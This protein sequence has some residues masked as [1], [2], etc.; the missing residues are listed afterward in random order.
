MSSG[1][2]IGECA[3]LACVLEATGRKPGNVTRFHDFD[4]LTYLDFVLSACAIAPVL[5]R[6]PELGVGPAILEAIRATRRFVTTN[7]NLGIVLLL[8]PLAATPREQPIRDGID[9]VLSG[10]TVADSRAAFEAIRLA[11][12]GGLGEAP[13]QDVRGKPT[14]PL[15]QAMALAA[16]RDLIAR[17]YAN[18]FREVFEIGVPELQSGPVEQAL[19][20]CQLRLMSVCIDSHIARKCGL[21]AAEEVRRRAATVE[22]S[23]AKAIA[24]FDSWL[25]HDGHRLNPGSTADLVAACLFIA[26]R[27][28]RIAVPIEFYEKPARR[29]P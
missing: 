15:Q 2:S 24:R 7:T 19:I 26:L 9:P 13:E 8:A 3:Q 17:Q 10:L 4:D 25:R 6:T 23:D 22:V 18:G 14:L 27:E 21:A 20:R 5:E 28:G 16:D 11:N 29:S 12:P 1:L